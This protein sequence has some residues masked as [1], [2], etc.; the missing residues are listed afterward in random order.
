[1]ELYKLK[2]QHKSFRNLRCNSVVNVS[3]TWVR[4]LNSVPAVHLWKRGGRLPKTA[5]LWVRPFTVERRCSLCDCGADWNCRSQPCL[6]SPG[7]ILPEK[8]KRSKLK[9]LRTVLLNSHGFCTIRKSKN[10]QGKPWYARDFPNHKQSHFSNPWR[11]K[12]TS[13]PVFPMV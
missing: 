6:A 11:F 13:I 3:H 2:T 8:K 1:M 4:H 10:H 5:L 9:T 12:E 7:S